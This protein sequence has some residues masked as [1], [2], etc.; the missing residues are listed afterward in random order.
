MLALDAKTGRKLF[1]FHQKIKLA[2][3][4]KVASG[5]IESGPAIADG[6][7]YWG[8]GLET[9]SSTPNG[10]GQYRNGGNRLYGFKIPYAPDYDDDDDHGHHH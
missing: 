3:G 4:S 8:A 6:W 5:G 7:V 9:G 1:E 10:A 2:D